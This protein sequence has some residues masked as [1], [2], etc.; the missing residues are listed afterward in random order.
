MRQRFKEK[1][2]LFRLAGLFGAGIVIFF[3]AQ[4]IF[5]PKG[6]GVYG[7]YRAGALDDNRKVAL[8]FSGRAACLD[9]H[10]DVADGQKGSRHASVGCEACHGPLAKHA[11]EDPAQSKPAKLEIKKLCLTCHIA[12]VAKPKGFKQVD[13]KEHMDGGPCG[14]CHDPHS[15]E[16]EPAK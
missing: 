11:L 14:T 16:K 4:M 9:C 15:P 8:S 2:H 13:A 10:Q 7:H 3:V 6:F 1:E 5:V 12:N